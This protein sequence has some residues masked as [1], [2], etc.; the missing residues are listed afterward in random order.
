MM[1]RAA[2]GVRRFASRENGST[3]K[4]RALRA[5]TATLAVLLIATASAYGGAGVRPFFFPSYLNPPQPS[6]ETYAEQLEK[7]GLS[8]KKPRVAVPFFFKQSAAETRGRTVDCS[9]GRPG[10]RC[11]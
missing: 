1:D 3:G 9:K 6:V 10:T 7:I 2:R 5:A 11:R 4:R 8:P